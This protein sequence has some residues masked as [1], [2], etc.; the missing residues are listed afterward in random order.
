MCACI[1]GDLACCGLVCA[2]CDIFRLPADQAVQDKILPW[3]R[4][5]GWLA[6][7]EG[8]A[9]AVERKMYCLGCRSDRT[10][11]HWS[12]DC[13]ILRCCVDEHHLEN[14]AQCA[15]FACERLIQWAGADARYAQALERLRAA[16]LQA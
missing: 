3:F 11:V 9:E 8:L 4:A 2:D 12:A 10:E 6:Q 15:E 16:L 14:C 5:Q 1:Q 13:A 7:D